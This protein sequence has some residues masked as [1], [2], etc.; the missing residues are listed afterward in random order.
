ML[1]HSS[2]ENLSKH[3]NNTATLEPEYYKDFC[4]PCHKLHYGFNTCYRD[5][6]TGGAMCATNIK[7]ENIVSDILGNLK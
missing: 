7:P 2:K 3:W 1:S 4:F 6:A 5:D